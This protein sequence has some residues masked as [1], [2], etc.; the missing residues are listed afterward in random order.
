MFRFILILT[1]IIFTQIPSA[2]C[3][4]SPVTL[5]ERA[6]KLSSNSRYAEAIPVF[7]SLLSLPR[8]RNSIRFQ[9]LEGRAR[10]RKFTAD[11][12]GAASD[13][14]SALEIP[15]STANKNALRLNYSDLL[16][17]TG[18]YDEAEKILSPMLENDSVPRALS[19]LAAIRK[20]QGHTDESIRLYKRILQLPLSPE[21][22]ANTA[23]NLGVLL[24]STG[25]AV[26]AVA[27][28]RSAAKLLDEAKAAGSNL[29][30][31][32]FTKGIILANLSLALSMNR[33]M[34]N[35]LSTNNLALAVLKESVG[36]RHPDYLN[37]LRKRGEILLMANDRK[38]AL[39]CFKPYFH[40]VKEYV[41]SAFPSMSEQS[42]LDYWK[43]IRPLI[44]EVFA[45]GNTNPDF[46]LDVALTRRAIALTGADKAFGAKMKERLSPTS[47]ALRKA[48]RRNEVAV[49][50][51][52]YP[53]IASDG[54]SSDR[55]A[56][57]VVFPAASR[58]TRFI[59]LGKVSDITSTRMS[60]QTLSHHLKSGNYRSKN[61][62]YSDTTLY[63]IIWDKILENLPEK[64]VIHFAPDGFLNLLAI[65]SLAIPHGAEKEFSF[66]RHTTL[67]NLI[68]RN[69]KKAS[70]KLLVAGGLDY[71]TYPAKPAETPSSSSAINHDA[72]NY[73]TRHLNGRPFCFRTLPGMRKEALRV[74]QLSK[75]V[76]LCD[77]LSE[78]FFK[79]LPEDIRAIHL[80]T[81]GY[82]LD[83]EDND[84]PLFMRD[85]VTADNS[86]LASGLVLSGANVLHTDPSREDALLSAREICDLD[87]SHLDF[88]ILAA[89]QTALGEVNDEGPA[90][91]IRGL[92]KAGARTIL[93]T[94][95]EVDDNATLLFMTMF[96]KALADGGSPSD[97]ISTARR[98]LRDYEIREEVVESRFDPATL[99]S[100]FESTGEFRSIYPYR[101]PAYWAPF[102]LIDD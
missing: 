83:I 88:T 35:A 13:Y 17:V 2:F 56:A 51:I 9:A 24:M 10:C 49:D 39:E 101:D 6:E 74:A 98:C 100:V 20:Y 22:K 64:S 19:N 21:E 65:E 73:L 25:N 102:I 14:L 33:E 58:T 12:G 97:A 18:R 69:N 75:D 27:T 61:L 36:D 59:D 41:S 95:W 26:Q 44:S 46:L 15:A 4:D 70:G 31:Q 84:T 38:A 57:L 50:F 81:H 40:Q 68:N 87:L 55:L 32:D 76:I 63:H 53:E 62:L 67:A 48:L 3:A 78:E 86:L 94:L 96:H 28:L 5:L 92:K 37:A 82:A 34:D 93:A 16:I 52:I 85:S 66:H 1:I 42:R 71:D 29:K 43:K 91:L 72:A 45:T 90:G 23:Q 8:L 47:A 99:C 30:Q 89:C 60:G 80:S 11:Y 79:H 7:D 77:T 54:T